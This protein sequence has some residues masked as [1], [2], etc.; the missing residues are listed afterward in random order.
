VVAKIGDHPIT[1]KQLD[2][3]IKSQLIA[4]DS[5]IYQLKRRALESIADD[6]LIDQAARGANLSSADYLKRETELKISQPTDQQIQAFYSQHQSQIGQPLE[7]VKPQIAGFMRAKEERQARLDLI[8]R[9]SGDKKLTILIKPPRAE[10]ATKGFPSL[11]PES[12]PVIIVEF[13]DF[14]CPYCRKAEDSLKS[15]RQKYGDK[16]RLVYR[17]FP[18][19]KIH[20]NAHKAAEASNCAA[21]Q[22]KFWE[23][24]DALFANPSKLGPNDLKATAAKLGIN[25]VEFGQCLDGG[26]YAGKV[27]SDTSAGNDLGVE[28]TPTFFINGRTLSGA[29]SPQ[30]FDSIIDEELAQSAQ[31]HRIAT[32]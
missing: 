10:V 17:D 32:Q 14:Q 30:A 2:A 1:E 24:H 16:V 7:K 13:S 23:Y 11:G 21:D 28:G 6:Y 5:Q 12:A 19:D 4:L 22:G 3:K 27:S 31:K 26:K 25:A 8:A 15:V 18:L 20:P 29:A 9:L